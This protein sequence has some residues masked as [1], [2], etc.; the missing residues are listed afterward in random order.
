MRRESAFRWAGGVVVLIV[1]GSIIYIINDRDDSESRGRT[2]RPKTDV[3]AERSTTAQ[4]SD[5]QIAVREPGTE[6]GPIDNTAFYQALRSYSKPG[7]GSTLSF[8]FHAITGGLMGYHEKFGNYPKGDNAAIAKALLFGD[9]PSG[10]KIVG[11]P[12]KL[13]PKGEFLDPWK[14]P[15]FIKVTDETIEIRSAGPDRILWNKDDIAFKD[16]TLK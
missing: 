9:N 15:Y 2:L 12:D 10:E 7:G 6:S 8:H 16:K 13:S 5:Q 11:F 1:V 3:A 14:V 4:P